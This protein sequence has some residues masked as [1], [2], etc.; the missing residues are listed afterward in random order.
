MTGTN[1]CI[2]RLDKPL[3][4]SSGV[5]FSCDLEL[6]TD[7][8]FKSIRLGYLSSINCPKYEIAGTCSAGLLAIITGTKPKLVNSN[9]KIES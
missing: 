4:F 3:Y 7:D 5:I 2:A 8:K 6:L 1:V 9:A